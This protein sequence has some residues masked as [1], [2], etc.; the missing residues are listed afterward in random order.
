GVKRQPAAG[1]ARWCASE[2]ATEG[3]PRSRSIHPLRQGSYS[4]TPDPRLLRGE[5]PHLD[6]ARRDNFTPPPPAAPPPPTQPSPVGCSSRWW[7]AGVKS[8]PS[9]TPSNV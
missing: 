8:Q 5:R 1:E 7:Q 4:G 3:S 9:P 6:S 2:E